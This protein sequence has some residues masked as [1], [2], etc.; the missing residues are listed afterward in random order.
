MVKDIYGQTN[1][2][3]YIKIREAAK[4]VV[5]LRNNIFFYDGQ[6]PT[7]IKLERGGGEA[8]F[9]GFPNREQKKVKSPSISVKLLFI[10]EINQLTLQR[11]QSMYHLN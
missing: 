11:L 4:S 7:A 1:V 5:S 2:S 8:S 6:V 3:R 10:P 9:C